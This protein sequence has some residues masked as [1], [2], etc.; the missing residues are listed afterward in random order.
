MA[1]LKVQC[2]LLF[3]LSIEIVFAD[4]NDAD[5]RSID[6]VEVDRIRFVY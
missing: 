4:W 2:S 6:G 3:L 5:F 1:N